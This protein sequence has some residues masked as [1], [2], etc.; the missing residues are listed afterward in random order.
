VLNPEALSAAFLTAAAPI[1]AQES[2]QRRA[3]RLVASLPDPARLS[4]EER[5]GIIARYAAVLEGNFIYWLTATHLSV[6]SR[7]ARRI[8]HEN[9]LEEVRDNHPG[10]LRRFA[11]AARAFP[12]DA[13]HF[14][15]HSRLQEVRGFVSGLAGAQLLL[16]M[17]FFEGFIGKFMPYLAVLAAKQG[18]REYQYTDVHSVVDIDH[19]QQL[20]QA[21][22]AEVST[23]PDVSLS[24]LLDGVTVL[25]H[26]LETIVD[27][28]SA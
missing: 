5:R 2:I 25:Q 20:Y 16:M 9:L 18:S 24:S 22:A 28:H 7:E 6:S 3:E 14:A 23:S 17:A 13:D 19:T 4:Q 10:M 21:F 12:T 11:I 15:I 26:L 27:G 8:V 1:S